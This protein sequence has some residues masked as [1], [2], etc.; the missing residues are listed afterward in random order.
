MGVALALVGG[1]LVVLS[2]PIGPL[3]SQYFDR[4]LFRPFDDLQR[5]LQACLLH[6]RRDK[7]AFDELE[8]YFLKPLGT[9]D[10]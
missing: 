9:S 7:V 2:P 5:C 4:S 3:A 10:Y 1:V 6:S 8:R